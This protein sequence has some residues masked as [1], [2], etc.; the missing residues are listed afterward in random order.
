MMKNER[1]GSSR[2]WGFI[3]IS[4]SLALSTPFAAR[5]ASAT[6]MSSSCHIWVAWGHP[7]VEEATRAAL[8]SCGYNCHVMST[9][10]GNAAIAIAS[11]SPP[12]GMRTQYNCIIG[13]SR[14]N[15][16]SPSDA[17]N[18][19]LNDCAFHGGRNC[20]ATWGPYYR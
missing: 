5:A 18:E 16:T 2:R 1:T 20:S 15:S 13:L 3:L 12:P 19:A 7:T 8:R 14:T 10:P 17:V 6:A 9:N 11:G 4:I